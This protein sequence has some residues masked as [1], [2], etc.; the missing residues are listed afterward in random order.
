MVLACVL[1]VAVL[2]D[3]GSSLHQY[4]QVLVEQ[5]KLVSDMKNLDPASLLSPRLNFV[6]GLHP[7]R[8]A[9]GIPSRAG[10]PFR[11]TP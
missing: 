9:A 6:L 10:Q 8:S 2:D 5:S 4:E 7:Q 11:S 1:L 3:G